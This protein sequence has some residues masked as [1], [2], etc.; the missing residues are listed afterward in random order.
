MTVKG[1]CLVTILQN[2]FLFCR[3]KKF[4][5]A[6]AFFNIDIYQQFVMLAYGTQIVALLELKDVNRK[7]G[8]RIREYKRRIQKNTKKE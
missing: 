4:I 6:E 3:R 2:I 5:Y 8:R 7:V 1:N